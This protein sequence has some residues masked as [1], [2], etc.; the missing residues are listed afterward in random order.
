MISA[1]SVIAGERVAVWQANPAS[2]YVDTAVAAAFA[3]DFCGFPVASL[4]E[5]GTD[6]AGPTGMQWDPRWLGS[7]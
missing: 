4:L 1:F 3:H 7:D 5:T 6:A 2:H